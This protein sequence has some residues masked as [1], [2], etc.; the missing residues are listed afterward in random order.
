LLPPY[1]I[2]FGLITH[3]LYDNG[4]FANATWYFQTII[5]HYCEHHFQLLPFSIMSVKSWNRNNERIVSMKHNGGF[6]WYMHTCHHRI[7]VITKFK[8]NK[9]GMDFV[10]TITF[11][12]GFSFACCHLCTLHS[13]ILEHFV[14]LCV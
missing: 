1:T 5:C 7:D 9:L 2:G 11:F 8:C 10:I 13:T 3:C 6:L 4:S 14:V 12:C